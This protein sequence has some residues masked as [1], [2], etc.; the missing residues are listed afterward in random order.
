MK[1][2]NCYLSSMGFVVVV[3]FLVLPVFTQGQELKAQGYLMTEYVVK[4]FMAKEFEKATIEEK[5]MVADVSF[6]YGWNAYST[7]D[8]HYYFFIPIGK[9]VASLDSLI[10]AL[11]EAEARLPENYETLEKRMAGAYEYYREMVV[12]LRPDLSYTPAESNIKPEGS[13]YVFFELTYILPEK[14]KEFEA[15]YKEWA[16]LCQKIGFRI[17]YVAYRGVFGTDNPFYLS[18]MIART[19]ADTFAEEERIMK[20][21]SP[22]QQAELGAMYEKAFTFF[23]KYETR[24]GRSRPDLSYTPKAK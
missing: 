7:E 1:S 16:A 2:K 19:Q 9:D 23:R 5:A 11:T 21:L 15:Y 6:P 4:P 12:Y 14:E 17:G 20:T 10:A 24:H 13:N 22:K 8:F 3:C 18:T